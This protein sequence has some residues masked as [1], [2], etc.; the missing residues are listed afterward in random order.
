MKYKVSARLTG[1]LLMLAVSSTIALPQSNS[2]E[3][4][5]V[6]SAKPPRPLELAEATSMYSQYIDPVNGLAGDELVRYALAHNGELA[7]ARQMIAEARGRLPRP[8]SRPTQCSRLAG[9]TPLTLQIIESDSEPSCHWSLVGDEARESQSRPP[10]FKYAKPK[11]RT[12]SEG[13]QPTCE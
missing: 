3:I 11:W 8:D 2:H 7:A 5:L 9:R 12:S 13:S 6:I 4:G 10:S 1:A